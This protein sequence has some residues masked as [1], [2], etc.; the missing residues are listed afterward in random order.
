MWALG[1]NISIA[2][3]VGMIALMGLD[4]ETGVLLLLFME[5]AYK[6]AVQE[7]RM[8]TDQGP[9]RCDHP[10]FCAPFAPQNDDGDG[11]FCGFIADHVV[12]R[13]RG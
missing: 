10:G 12:Q 3:W 13:C 4:A 7:N 8:N 11:R 9:K 1:F 5:L 2:V 6:K